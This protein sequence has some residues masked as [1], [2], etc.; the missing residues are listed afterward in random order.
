KIELMYQ[1]VMALTECIAGEV[2]Q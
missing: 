2:D 1:S